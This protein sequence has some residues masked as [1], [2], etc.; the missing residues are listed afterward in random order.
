MSDLWARLEHQ[1]ALKAPDLLAR[2][3]PG[4]SE[5][6]I[7]AY[8]QAVG[9]QLPAD[10][11]Q[12]YLRHDGCD[13]V[14]SDCTNSHQ[15]LG[16][17]GR[18]QWRPLESSLEA[19]HFWRA[20]YD[21]TDPD[22]LEDESTLNSSAMVRDFA[23]PPPYWIPLAHET[24]GAIDL[25]VDLRPGTAGTVGQLVIHDLIGINIWIEASSLQDYLLCL[26]QGLEN[27]VIQPVKDPD[28]FMWSWCSGDS[29]PVRMAGYKRPPY[30]INV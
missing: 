14:V 18:Y 12:A 23:S 4:A 10:V 11:R 28:I 16:L 25:Y 22:N 5:S 19:W 17:F 29:I 7:F 3:R 27:G 26:A 30:E 1:L 9:H 24:N 13:Y 6:A 2:L 20:D 8:E 21:E 15:S